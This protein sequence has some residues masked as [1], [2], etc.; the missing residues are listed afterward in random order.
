MDGAL[1]SWFQ[2]RGLIDRF[3]ADLPIFLDAYRQEEPEEFYEVFGADLIIIVCRR[4]FFMPKTSDNA[5]KRFA[6]HFST[7]L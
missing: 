2:S 5:E 7:N 1:Y 4:S 3:R 6:L